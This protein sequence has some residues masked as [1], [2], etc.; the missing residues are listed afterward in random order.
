MLVVLTL[1]VMPSALARRFTGHMRLSRFGLEQHER[2]I[3]V[4][5]ADMD[6][7][8]ATEIRPG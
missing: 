6:G 4:V 8:G 3:D 5:L 1:L 2:G 7:T